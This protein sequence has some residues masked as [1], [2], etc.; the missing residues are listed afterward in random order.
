MKKTVSNLTIRIKPTV[1]V[2]N[3]KKDKTIIKS[4]SGGKTVVQKATWQKGWLMAKFRQFG[5]YQALI[6]DVPPSVNA[7]PTN[8]TKAT[9]IVFTPT[10]NF[11]TIKSFRVEVDGQWLRFTNDKGRTWIYTFDEKF[12][13]GEHQLKVRVEDEAGNKKHRHLLALTRMERKFH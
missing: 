6:D 13:K 1:F 2:P 7:V 9:R 8:L 4:I 12:P 11:N 3:D 10:D 5:T